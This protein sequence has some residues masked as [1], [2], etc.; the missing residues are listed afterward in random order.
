MDPA[1]VEEFRKLEQEKNRLEGEIKHLY[2][3]LTEDGMPGVAGPLVDDEGFPRGD[4]DLYA[5]RQA[6]NKYA[7]AQ[8]DH[9][10][11]MRKIEEAILAIHATTKVDVP[12][13]SPPDTKMDEEEV[14][15]DNVLLQV[16]LTTPFATIDE[17]SMASPAETAGLRVGDQI[18]RFGPVSIQ[19]TGDL[20]ACFNAIRELVPK[21]VG[22]AIS[23]V[24][25]R[26]EP[27]VRTEL[28]LIPQQWAGRGLLGCHMAP[29][30]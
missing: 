28:E 30:L 24:V 15:P 12:R 4:I 18:C 2:E 21:N 16:K 5:V 23:V 6:R 22:N 26:G 25:L 7:C 13:A 1:A 9:Q 10:E 19:D 8:T 29:K 17:V 3:Y 20:N 14:S 27:P 11:V